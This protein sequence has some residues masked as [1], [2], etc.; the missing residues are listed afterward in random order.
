MRTIPAADELAA[1][2]R[3][4]I[5]RTARRLRQEAGVELSPSQQAALAT[6]ERHGPLAPSELADR[7]GVKR[8]TV[9]RIVE[10]LVEAG[11]VERSAAPA[12][13]RSRLLAITPAGRERLALDRARKDHF[14]ARRL[15]QLSARDR[16]TLAR[17]ADLLDA[18][19][20]RG[21]DAAEGARR[22]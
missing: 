20:E 8:P 15:E 17:A 18:L 1:R 3:L 19:L 2:L 9:T 10:R 22:A 16:A 11:L 7:E 5:T 6:I 13:G 12:D 4:S 14:L 21:D